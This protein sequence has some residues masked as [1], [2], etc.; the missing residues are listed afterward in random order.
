MEAGPVGL[1]YGRRFDVR[2]L[3][4]SVVHMVRGLEIDDIVTKK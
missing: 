4:K 1:V 3:G 2:A